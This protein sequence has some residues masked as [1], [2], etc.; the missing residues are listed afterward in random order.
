MLTQARLKELLHYDPTTG[1]WTRVRCNERRDL[2]GKQAGSID[3]SGYLHIRVDGARYKA[4]RLA[5]LYMTG[6]WP[7][8][9]VDHRNM[10]RT[11]C[12][13][14]NLRP[15][16]R[17]LNQANVRVR[18]DNV[19]GIKGVTRFKGRYQARINLANGSREFIGSFKSADDAGRAYQ[20]RARAV[21][22][23]YGRV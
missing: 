8:N 18:S 12:K 11:D 1:I 4:H 5:F 3:G 7:A 9:E 17:R 22:G 23:E 14:S 13:W 20:A 21:F 2:V 19:T 6:A 10:S 16:T 15:A